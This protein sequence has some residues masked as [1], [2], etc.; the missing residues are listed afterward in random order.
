M[1]A[2]GGVIGCFL[3]F[4]SLSPAISLAIRP[5]VEADTGTA[6]LVHEVRPPA[7]KLL[8]VV[9]SETGKRPQNER[10]S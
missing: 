9:S 3:L 2:G 4:S 5:V 1:F 10:M 6:A 8:S 7:S